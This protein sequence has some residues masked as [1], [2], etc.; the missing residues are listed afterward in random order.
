MNLQ[1][2]EPKSAEEENSALFVPWQFAEARP[3]SLN[4]H[5]FH[6]LRRRFN[7]EY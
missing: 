2:R 3:R 1:R 5:S 4:A 6:T 7:R